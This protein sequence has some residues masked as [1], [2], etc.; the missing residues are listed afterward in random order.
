[1]SA[2]FLKNRRLKYLRD[3]EEVDLLVSHGAYKDK[4]NWLA[5]DTRPRN[6]VDRLGGEYQFMLQLRC[7]R[8]RPKQLWHAAPWW[9]RGH[10]LMSQGSYAATGGCPKF[11]TVSVDEWIWSTN[12]IT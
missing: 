11:C 1:M 6:Y 7:T 8:R 4:P 9:D 10:F 5:N 2:G 12:Q 3:D